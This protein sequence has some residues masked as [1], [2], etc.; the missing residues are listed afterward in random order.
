[1]KRFKEFRQGDWRVIVYDDEYVFSGPEHF[2]AFYPGKCAEYIDKLI[3]KRLGAGWELS[4]VSALPG[5]WHIPRSLV[6]D[7]ER[8][9]RK[10]YYWTEGEG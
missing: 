5:K 7:V 2:A 4:I 3:L 9:V 10:T 8:H 1:M 6:S